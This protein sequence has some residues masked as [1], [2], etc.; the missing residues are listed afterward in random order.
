MNKKLLIHQA[1]Y[2][3]QLL[4][5]RFGWQISRH[6]PV[7]TE[8][9]VYEIEKRLL[10]NPKSP[11]IFDVGAWVGKTVKAHLSVFPDATV[12]AFEPFPSSFDQL[13]NAFADNGSV[14]AQQF[15]MSNVVGEATF[16]SNNIET[17]NSLLAS[18]STET[19][20]DFFRDTKETITVQ[21]TTLDEYCAQNDVAS[22][23]LLKLDIQGGELN[24]LKGATQLLQAKAISLI[25]CEVEFIEHYKDNPLYHDVASFLEGYGYSFYNFYGAVTDEHGELSWAD[26]L[27]YSPNLRA[28]VKGTEAKK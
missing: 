8:D 15:A 23:D 11:V 16:Y 3:L 7:K 21:T 24:A 28:V 9:N 27:F 14:Q 18:E 25:Y 5:H 17:T 19:S 26:A 1:K 4:L 22:I 6:N 13:Q 2:R 20:D 12:H 10:R